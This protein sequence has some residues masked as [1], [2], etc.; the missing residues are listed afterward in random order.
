MRQV[1]IS[2]SD[3]ARALLKSE[4]IRTLLLY[5]ENANQYNFLKV[6]AQ[7]FRKAKADIVEKEI[8]I[9]NPKKVSIINDLLDRIVNS[10]RDEWKGTSQ[11]F[12]IVSSHKKR[13]PCDLCGFPHLKDLYY[14]QNKLNRK[15]LIVGSTCINEFP[16][17]EFPGRKGIK[18]LK[19]EM[20]QNKRLKR[21]SIEIPGIAREIDDWE[22][23]LFNYDIL[24]PLKYQDEY[25]SLGEEVKVLYEKYLNGKV[26][27]EV[28]H[29][30]RK[31]KRKKE[32]MLSNIGLYN[33]INKNKLLVASNK[34]VNWLL[35]N[36]KKQVIEKL[37][38][39]GFIDENTIHEITEPDF[40][41][42]MN[43]I[44]AE[45][46]KGVGTF[47]YSKADNE[48][49][50]YLNNFDIKL[51]FP[52]EKFLDYFGN[53]LLDKNPKITFS[54]LN[55]FKIGRIR[56]RL[57]KQNTLFQI[58]R[59]LRGSEIS[60]AFDDYGGRYDYL[61]ENVVDIYDSR[62]NKIFEDNLI[63]FLD[64]YKGYALIKDSGRVK[65]EVLTYVNLN[66]S[67]MRTKKELEDIRMSRF[68]DYVDK[69]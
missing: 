31:A 45:K 38:V 46:L 66:K 10:C 56:D 2:I 51:Y 9:W 63:K 48:Y 24:I 49:V 4:K 8:S 7:K 19:R 39:T 47:E 1:G 52:L 57:S 17:I 35:T 15:K 20:N 5:S 65:R 30:I 55:I 37:K 40:I 50:L 53:L 16:N 44:F 14:I 42:K 43:P 11:P 28:F 36:G 27:E 18:Q 54:E 60:I 13:I 68:K 3:S 59:M 58:D 29:E 12:D 6:F 61:D 25:S 62:Y 23:E 33:S 41:I 32:K 21:I 64:D 67:K 34:I 22:T 69:G 26:T